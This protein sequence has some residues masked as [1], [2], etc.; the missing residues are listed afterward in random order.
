MTTPAGL[1]P[2][3]Y[4]GSR[5]EPHLPDPGCFVDASWD[6]DERAL[7]LAHLRGARIL[8]ASA[9]F[10]FCRF[11]CGAAAGSAEQSDGTFIWPDG[12]AHYVEQHDVRLPRLFV[13]HALGRVPALPR[14]GD[15][16][17]RAQTGSGGR[18]RTF[19]TDGRGG[20]V[21]VSLAD[22]LSVDSAAIRFVR[23]LVPASLSAVHERLMA[24]E[25][26]V[27]PMD[28]SDFARL[29][30]PPTIAVRFEEPARASGASETG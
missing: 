5:E 18:A 16:W 20:S 29:G 12:L 23:T 4:W 21:A 13:D 14:G 3:G 28:Y 17:W 15:A 11:R 30:P 10:A 22:G 8:W 19:L 9:G 2:L 6:A 1:I 27:L 26:F 25:T 24:G 7:V